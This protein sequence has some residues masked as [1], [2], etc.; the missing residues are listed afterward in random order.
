MQQ[1]KTVKIHCLSRALS[2]ITHNAKS[3][4]NETIINREAV[5]YDDQIKYVPCLSGNALR[6]KLIR[7]PG[8]MYL[9]KQVGLYGNANIDQLN[10]LFNGGSLTKSSTTDN[11]KHIAKMQELIPLV[12]LLGGSLTNQIVGGSLIVKRGVLVCEENRHSIQPQLPPGFLLPEEVL[13]SC[14]EF[15][16]EYQ[17]TRGDASRHKEFSSMGFSR[18]GE[19]MADG[20]SNLMIYNGQTVMAGAMFY[21]GFILQNI[22]QKEVGA[23]LHSLQMWDNDGAV[24]GGSGR[25]GHGQLQTGIYVEPVED[26]FGSDINIADLVLEYVEYVDA[27]KEDVFNWLFQVFP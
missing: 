3:S 10:F 14:Q 17:Y 20:K 2:P 15:I 21:H 27:H 18:Q 16:G 19:N 7:E 11:M 12:R 24:I 13:Q 26:W 8:A 25:I 9:I 6:H 22:S 1:I 4:G 5:Y 23:L